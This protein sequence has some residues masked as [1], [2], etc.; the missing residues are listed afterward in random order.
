MT[1]NASPLTGLDAKKKNKK[2][3]CWFV[4]VPFFASTSW[5]SISSNRDILDDRQYFT[6]RSAMLTK[7][8]ALELR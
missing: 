2:K 4:L 6:A 8:K 7:N 3:V 5:L 1:D